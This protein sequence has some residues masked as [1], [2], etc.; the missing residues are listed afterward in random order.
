MYTGWV[1]KFRHGTCLSGLERDLQLRMLNAALVK[2]KIMMSSSFC[3]GKA[4]TRASH[5]QCR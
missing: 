2:S 1:L 3:A 5:A 4:S